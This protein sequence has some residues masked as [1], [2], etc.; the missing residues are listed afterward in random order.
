[1]SPS[2]TLQIIVELSDVAQSPQRNYF[3]KH[4]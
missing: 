3:S 2:I 1:M 4:I